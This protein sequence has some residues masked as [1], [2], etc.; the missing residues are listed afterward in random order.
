M[1]QTYADDVKRSAFEL[2]ARQDRT[3]EGECVPPLS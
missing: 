2:K 3:L 1:Q